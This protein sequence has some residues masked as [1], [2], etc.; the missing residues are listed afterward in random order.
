MHF[1]NVYKNIYHFISSI[2]ISA[3]Y[4]LHIQFL[5]LSKTI[6]LLEYLYEKFGWI[7]T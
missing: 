4:N 7:L 2:C 3:P 1:N 5:S 6:H